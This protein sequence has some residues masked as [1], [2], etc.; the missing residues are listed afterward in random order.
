MDRRF[1]FRL[2]V[3]IMGFLVIIFVVAIAIIS[4]NTTGKSQPD[5]FYLV[6]LIMGCFEVVLNAFTFYEIEDGG[7][8]LSS[9]IKRTRIKWS[10][11]RCIK[12]QQGGKLI[13]KAF[14]VYSQDRKITITPLTR[15]YEK[16]LFQVVSNYQE[17]GEV[18]VDS[19]VFDVIKQK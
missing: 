14:V 15:Q 7:I 19:G 12:E 1:R 2:K 5:I 8:K 9:P 13:G 3:H 10:E 11:I 4:T 16:L 18:N 6:P 17:Q